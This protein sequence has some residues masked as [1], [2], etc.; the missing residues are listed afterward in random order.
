M[1]KAIVEEKYRTDP[2]FMIPRGVIIHCSATP[3]GKSI[4]DPIEEIGKWHKA[5][6]WKGIGY[7]YTIDLDGTIGEGRK[8]TARGAHTSGKHAIL[9]HW[10]NELI[11]IC[12]IGTDKYTGKQWQALHD[13][14]R[15]L[16]QIPVYNMKSHQIYTHNMFS[17]KTCPGFTIGKFYTWFLTNDWDA[18]SDHLLPNGNECKIF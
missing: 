8:L 2:N 13:C 1:W 4:G 10:S 9:K 15:G 3:N 16:L 5:R 6:G 18:V 17:K 11:G 14:I 12:M 7:H